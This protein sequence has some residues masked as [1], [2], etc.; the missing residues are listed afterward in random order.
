MQE[1]EKRL[2][3]EL[4]K[5]KDNHPDASQLA[6]ATPEVLGQLCLGRM[7]GVAYDSLR[8]HDLLDKVNREFKNTLK[9]GYDHNLLRNNS[10][11]D[12]VAMVSDLLS[13]CPVRVAMLKGAWL[14]AHYPGGYRTS[15]DI[16][17]L[18]DAKDVTEVG[19]MLSEAGFMQGNIR[20]DVFVPAGRREI[21]ESKMT[22]G[23]T[24][25]YIKQVNLPGMPYLEIDLNFSLD[26][27]PGDDRALQKMLE[28]TEW[29]GVRTT[30]IP[31]LCKQ[32]FFLHL[33][34]HLYKEATTL[35]W[36]AMQR[37]MTL[38]KFCDLYLLLSESDEKDIADL[39]ARAGELGLADVC[40]FGILWTADLFEMGDSPA[41][42]GAKDILRG[43]PDFLHTVTSPAEKKTFRYQTESITDRFF[44]QNRQK[45][46][47]EVTP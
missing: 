19:R 2:F 25:P 43:R 46:L 33:C 27:K 41:V 42:L 34:C 12:G 24:V 40:A 9:D 1:Q 5:F 28:K 21:I 6:Y 15:N 7:Q 31:T 44:M 23:E 22:R 13:A 45:D 39:F 29:R 37:D 18:L 26:Y 20:R 35:P 4:C 38:Y 3:K 10:F 16:D 30:R 32:D 11:F 14:C 8:R 47:R 17:L 36:I